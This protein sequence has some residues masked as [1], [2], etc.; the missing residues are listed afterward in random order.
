MYE[1]TRFD[2]FSNCFPLSLTVISIEPYYFFGKH[3]RWTKVTYKKV[4]F[5]NNNKVPSHKR[6]LAQIQ[7]KRMMLR[8]IIILYVYSQKTPMPSKS[9]WFLT[10]L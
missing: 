9:W 6:D 7:M 8:K 10:N 4:T 5:D 1:L 2:P 3:G